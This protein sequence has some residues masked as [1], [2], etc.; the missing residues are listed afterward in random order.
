M[1]RASGSTSRWLLDA[2]LL[3]VLRM[4]GRRLA[5]SLEDLPAG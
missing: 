5:R 2:Y 3:G 4:P 1:W